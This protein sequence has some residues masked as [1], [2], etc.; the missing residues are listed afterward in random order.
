LGTELVIPRGGGTG[1]NIKDSDIAETLA[2]RPD[3]FGTS[4][5]Q[6]VDDAVNTA[7]GIRAYHGSPHDFDQF[8][9]SSTQ[10]KFCTSA[11]F[12][13]SLKADILKRWPGGLTEFYGMTEGGGSCI[14]AAHLFPDKLHT[15]GQP[16]EGH[17][18]LLIDEDGKP[19][20][21]GEAGEVVGRSGSMMNGYHN[22]PAKTREAEWY[23]DQGRRHIRTG[24][25]GRFDA[26]GFLTLFDR[27]KD[28]IITGG[29]N[30]Y[31]S[32]MEAVLRKHEDI[33]DCAVIG[34][35]SEAWGETPVAVIVLR[36]GARADAEAVREWVNAQVGKTQRLSDI[37][38]VDELPRSA[39]GKILKRELRDQFAG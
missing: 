6:A 39:I 32:D 15:V 26:D 37:V 14:L 9:L 11:P 10:A 22:Q 34:V 20:P 36:A 4:Q 35:P 17:T 23:D 24:D 21:Q 33:A 2:N 18:I 13:A 19:V 8:D 25:I 31:P 5:K 7:R 38:A 29:F 30:V 28:M 3:L 1:S 12:H 16:A 27:K